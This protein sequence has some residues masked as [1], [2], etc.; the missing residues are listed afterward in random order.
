[1]IACSCG[2]GRRA[3]G[4]IPGPGV[5]GVHIAALVEQPVG[6]AAG[7]GDAGH[8]AE[9]QLTFDVDAPLLHAPLLEVGID[10]G[11]VTTVVRRIDRLAVDGE[12]GRQRAHRRDVVAGERVGV[13]VR[14]ILV[15]AGRAAHRR[16]V[17]VDAVATAQHGVGAFHRA[18]RE[19]DTRLDVAPVRLHADRSPLEDLAG[20]EVEIAE[21]IVVFRLGRGDHVGEAQGHGQPVVHPPVVVDEPAIFLP[22]APLDRSVQ[23]V[24]AAT[25]GGQPQQQAGNRVAASIE[26][27]GGREAGG[28]QPVEAE[29]PRECRVA[30][31]VQLHRAHRPADVQRMRALD[32]RHGVS[33]VK[34]V[35]APLE[36]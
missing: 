7:V 12:A 4:L 15:R 13:G 8:R 11:P 17:V 18:P 20:E 32:H 26:R 21:A 1:M 28:E 30:K 5:R 31:K 14:W 36:G 25:G 10:R 16:H 29:L 3:A 24:V 23:L 27:S 33:E 6:V 9:W 34:Y 22:A 35:R 2:Y 19:T